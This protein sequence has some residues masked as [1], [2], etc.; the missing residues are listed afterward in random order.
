MA[1]QPREPAHSHLITFPEALDVFVTR[2]GEITAALGSG[3]AEGVRARETRVQEA[4]AARAQGDVP[5]AVGAIVRA[6][7]LLADLAGT[8][9]TLDG[10][11][12]RAMA[13]QFRA[14]MA[15]GAV[16]DAKSAADVMR[17]QSGTTV[18]PRKEG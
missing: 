9:P 3:K 10:P 18:V 8:D 7:E 4:R 5:R 6:M 13:A 15:R 14:A 1:N 2:M 17:E 12:L 16:A 11:Q